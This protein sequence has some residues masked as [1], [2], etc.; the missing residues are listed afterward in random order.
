MSRYFKITK[1]LKITL[2]NFNDKYFKCQY[3]L[4]NEVKKNENAYVCDRFD[5]LRINENL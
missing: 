4:F 3:V 2:L 5:I 1:I